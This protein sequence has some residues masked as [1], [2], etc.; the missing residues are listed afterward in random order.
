MKESR[1]LDCQFGPH[2]YKQKPTKGK[3]LWLQS[4][5]KIGCQAHIDVKG[6]VLYPEFAISEVERENL[7]NWKLRCLQEERLEM[8]RKEITVKK[9]VKTLM[10]TFISM[11]AESAH[12]GHPTGSAGIFAQKLHPLV[13]QKI[14]EMVRSGI[15]DTNEIKHCL[16]YHVDTVI[17]KDLDR[18][19]T[20]GDRA[21]YPLL[22]DIRNHVSKAKKALELSKFDLQNL[23]LKIEEWKASSPHSSFF[24]RPYKSNPD[25]EETPSGKNQGDETLLY[26]QQEE[27]QKSQLIQYGNTV[28][29]MDATYKTTKYSIPLFFVCVKTNVSYSVVAEF[30]IQSETKDDIFEALSVLKLWNP[31]WEPKF[32]LTDYSDAEIGAINKLF[33][34]TQVYMCEFH[35][36]QAWERW[37][38]DRKHGL[39][40]DQ[41]SVVLDKLRD[42][43]NVP[44]NYSDSDKPV[45]YHY[46]T[47]VEELK[48]TKVWKNSYDIQQW[49]NNNWLSCPK[50]RMHYVFV[51]IDDLF[52]SC[53]HNY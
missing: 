40:S 51:Y 42:C 41:A 5:R 36:E 1:I 14:L 17:V 47:A 49:L 10:K 25:T 7:S 16:K 33:P 35:R 37:V 28:T 24:F 21:F 8:L 2:Y 34:M 46:L 32:F 4:T 45:D 15:S 6:F 52:C 20:P 31:D 38:K 43:A 3:K 22:E 18:K 53:S 27:W 11:P 23:Q 48:E 39:T 12:S 19:P 30:I 26:V 13:S 9:P 29:L 50:V 44:P